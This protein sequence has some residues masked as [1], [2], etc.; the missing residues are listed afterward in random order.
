MLTAI[1]YWTICVG[2]NRRFWQL[3]QSALIGKFL[4]AAARANS[5]HLLSILL[6]VA[7][8]ELELV[9]AVFI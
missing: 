8:T 4:D 6:Y 2:S 1:S 7:Y 9:K 5:K 3:I